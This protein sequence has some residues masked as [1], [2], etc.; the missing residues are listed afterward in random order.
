V[1]CGLILLVGIG[2]CGSRDPV[3]EHVKLMNDYADALEKGAGQPKIDQIRK[4]IQENAN[5]LKALPEV[6]RKKLAEQH[7]SEYQTAHARVTNA[8]ARQRN[9]QFDDGG[10]QDLSGMMGTGGRK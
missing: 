2:G 10:I 9:K 6:E 7:K 8:L 1:A 4:R 5:K 3:M